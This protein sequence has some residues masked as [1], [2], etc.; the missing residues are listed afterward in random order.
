MMLLVQD[1]ACMAFFRTTW[2]TSAFVLPPL[3]A[4]TA[5]C[6]TTAPAVTSNVALRAPRTIN[7]DAGT[8]I[9]A[10]SPEVMETFASATAACAS[11]TVQI[12]LPPMGTRCGPQLK[13][14]SRGGAA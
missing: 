9:R 3:F 8:R 14:P 12:D 1:T 10:G 5:V 11:D 2:R 4:T 6:P 7:T 13:D